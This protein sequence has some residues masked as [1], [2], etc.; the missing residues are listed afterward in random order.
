MKGLGD[1]LKLK[2]AGIPQDNG[3][4]SKVVPIGI[5]KTTECFKIRILSP[6]L[7]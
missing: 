4:S 2:V 6:D 1:R 7:D 3:F 5:R